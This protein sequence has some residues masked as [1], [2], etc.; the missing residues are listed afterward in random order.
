MPG[1][2]I[3]EPKRNNA[4]IERVKKIFLRR[5]GVLKA[6]PNAAIILHSFVR[7]LDLEIFR[8]QLL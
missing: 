1:V 6:F 5:S 2:G 3:T 4:I 8:V 7:S